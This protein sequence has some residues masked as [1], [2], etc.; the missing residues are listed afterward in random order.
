MIHSISFKIAIDLIKHA[1]IRVIR[2][3]NAKEVYAEIN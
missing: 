1:S 3:A 2:M